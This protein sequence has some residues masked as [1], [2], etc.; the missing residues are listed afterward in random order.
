MG[1]QWGSRA[2]LGAMLTAI[3]L[4]QATAQPASAPP[5][6]DQSQIKAEYGR[7]FQ[8][9][10]ADVGNLDKTFHFAQVAILAGDYE[11][12]IGSL[13]RMLLVN[14]SLP[15]VR[16]ELGVLYYRLNSYQVARNY[17]VSALETPNVPPEVAERVKIFL[18]EIDQKLSPHRLNGSIYAGLRYETNANAGPD[19]NNIQVFGLPARLADQFTSQEDWTAFGMASLVHV[20]D[21]MTQDSTSWDSLASLYVSRHQEHTE[22]DLTVLSLST[23]PRFK[24]SLAD[25]DNVSVRPYAVLDW[26]RLADDTY[27]V[28]PGGG[29]TL[30]KGFD[31]GSTA[32]LS[33]E[34]RRRAFND[35]SDHPFNSDQ[36][37]WE[38]VARLQGTHLLNRSWL[39]HGGITLFDRTAEQSWEANREYAANLGISRTYQPWYASEVPWVTTLTGTVAFTEY[40]APDPTVNPTEARE[41]LDLRLTLIQTVPL[42]REWALVATVSHSIRDSSLPNFEHDNTIATLGATWRF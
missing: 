37:G 23:G 15:R 16:L 26:V 17:L 35:T 34:A 36:T 18:D 13:E 5:D 11:G 32:D 7:A 8:A 29:L 42:D 24:L 22:V 30:S 6:L 39:V 4:A 38:Y 21:F 33:L 41:D 3:S 10:M 1:K 28:A 40:D 14:P 9:M 20:Y 19:S 2:L 27:Y 31:D 25:V 12:A